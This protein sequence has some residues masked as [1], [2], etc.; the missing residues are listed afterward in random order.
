[1]KTTLH[2]MFAA[3][4]G[5]RPW[6]TLTW[7]LLAFTVGLLVRG[8]GP[9]PEVASTAPASV[10]DAPA[11]Y[12]C[13]MHPAIRLEDP[14]AK[15]PICFMDLIPVTSS[16]TRAGVPELVLDEAAMALAEVQTT[17][18]R[19]S[20]PV[21]EVRMFGR[22][23]YD[24][25][26][27]A[28]IAAYFPGRLERLFVDYPGMTVREGDHLAEV[29][30][31][32]LLAAFEELRQARR[33]VE[34]SRTAS[35]L[36][37]T[38]SKR[39]LEA[40]REKLRLF[41]VDSEQILAAETA[42]RSQDR[43][44]IHAPFGGVVTELA[45]IEGGYVQ[46]GDAIVTLADP[47][48][49]WLEA[50]AYESQLSLLRWGQ[51]LSFTVAARPGEVFTGRISFLAPEVDRRTRTAAVRVTVDNADGRLKPGMF[52]T[53]V[54]S[55]RL[56]ADGVVIGEDFSGKWVSPMHPEIVKDRPG[57]CDVC[58]MPLVP[59]AQ[60]GLDASGVRHEAPLVVP[61]S[62]VLVTGTRALVYVRAAD[63]QEPTFEGREIVLGD[64]AGDLYV[65]RAGLREGELVVS[66]GAFKIDSAMQI[67]GKP[68]MMNDS[69]SMAAASARLHAPVAFH[70]GLARVF[71]RYLEAQEALG[72]DDL[73]RFLAA[74]SGLHEVVEDVDLAGLEGEALQV[75]RR[76]AGSLRVEGT[77]ADLAS[78]RSAFER[79]SRA[80]ID[81]ARGF[82]VSGEQTVHLAFC[83]MAFDDTGAEW[84][85]RGETVL[86]PYFGASMLRC[87]E[88]REAF[89]KEFD[90]HE[91]HDHE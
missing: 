3:G 57:T 48:R 74:A 39:M 6:V 84:L 82:G 79:M 52:A 51:E 60:L 19:R 78:A 69:R 37:R 80:A 20:F 40:A 16:T 35:E 59:A 47:R 50:E 18:V 53:A 9:R 67:E 34:Q 2:R 85:Q 58:G 91:G 33:S 46:T 5:R 4:L 55:A 62:A 26:R 89:T 36:V 17:P 38:S 66:N 42:A 73:A 14:K 31:P 81:L 30:S 10:A 11:F 54:V 22:L 8:A 28:R 76:A 32:D 49:L 43:L 13:S 44:T 72:A 61:R 70:E 83:P 12:T 25:T 71:D 87:G 23:E 86:N 41:G 56:A 75:W 7:V 1:M 21:A 65:V 15:C 24:L 27:V 64:R 77:P 90:A 45:A 88:I 63:Q 68:S 29:Y